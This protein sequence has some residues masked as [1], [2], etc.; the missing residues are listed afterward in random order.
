[1]NTKSIM[2]TVFNR[3]NAKK[4]VIEIVNVYPDDAEYINSTDVKVSMEEYQPEQYF[5]YFD[6]GVVNDDGEPDEII[7]R[8]KGRTCNDCIKVGVERIKIRRSENA[9][10]SH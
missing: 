6:Y 2:A 8:S 1:M 3:P 7:I 9:N 5:I 10:E 4:N